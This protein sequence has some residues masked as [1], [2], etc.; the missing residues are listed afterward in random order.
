MITKARSTLSVGTPRSGTYS[1]MKLWKKFGIESHHERNRPHR[2]GHEFEDSWYDLEKPPEHLLGILSKW[3][4]GK[5]SPDKPYFEADCGKCMMIKLIEQAVPWFD[6]FVLVRE[7]LR[8]ANAW[9]H[10]RDVNNYRGHH[11]DDFLDIWITWGSWLCY[12]ITK[13][14][15]KPVFLRFEDYIAG[16][17]NE[18]LL[19]W[20]GIE[21]SLEN[22]AIVNNHLKVEIHSAGPYQPMPVNQERLRLCKQINIALERLC[23]KPDA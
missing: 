7:P 17:Y 9:K 22:L 1:L 21:K 8:M 13:M 12:Q 14:K 10:W 3:N 2:I 15:K 16:K 19:D 4:N 11:P 5:L 20:Y 18:F 23:E 6:F